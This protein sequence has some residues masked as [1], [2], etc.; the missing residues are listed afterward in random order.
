MGKTKP[1]PFAPEKDIFI[2]ERF[3]QQ[4][5]G[6]QLYSIAQWN[7]AR[8]NRGLNRVNPPKRFLKDNVY[9]HPGVTHRP[10]Y[11][12]DNFAIPYRRAFPRKGGPLI[13]AFKV[14]ANNQYTSS[15]TTPSPFDNTFTDEVI[16][17]LAPT[18]DNPNNAVLSKPGPSGVKRKPPTQLTPSTTPR[19]QPTP[20]NI[21]ST[22]AT[23]VNTRAN[24]PAMDVDP[25]AASSDKG[26]NATSDGGFDSAQ[27][28][29]TYIKRPDYTYRGGSMSFKKIH[30]MKS[31]ALPF[32]K[33][34]EGGAQWTVTPLTEIPWQYM[35]FYMSQDEFNRIPAGSY[36]N[37]CKI[38]I[39]VV[40]ASTGFVSG[41]TES[42]LATFQHPKIGMLGLDLPQ[43]L[44][45]GTTRTVNFGAN[46]KPMSTANGNNR[47]DFILKQY[48]VDQANVN[49]DM[50]DDNLA[51]LPGTAFPIVYNKRDYFCVYQP[52]LATA[53]TQGF[54]AAV[55]PGYEVLN[56]AIT[57]FNL[58]DRM[59]DSVFEREYRFESA[60]IGARYRP[61]EIAVADQQQTLG[62]TDYYNMQRNITNTGP[63]GAGG[64]LTFGSTLVGTTYNQIK[65][66]DY[67]GTEIEKGGMNRRGATMTKPARQPS[68]H[69]GI[70]QI[71][72]L[73]AGTDN[74]RADD[75]V[76]ADCYFVVTAEMDIQC[77]NYPNRFV[78]P[79]AFNVSIENAET[80]IALNS[81]A[82]DSIVT[83]G[84]KD[85]A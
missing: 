23:M 34:V 17:E 22:T 21:P 2:N 84:L 75:F 11:V 25:P 39:Q 6:R 65:L 70:K 8:E 42:E 27:G 63:S 54:T 18:L 73:Q 35:Y 52:S 20:A 71:P 64:N 81:S 83:F 44:R 51:P 68:V 28:P 58:N 61:L 46:L 53:V 57:Q 55:A 32:T 72:K 7:K 38:S 24:P 9:G 62:K 47:A 3:N 50:E 19:S 82:A 80:G 14:Q 78:L 1:E 10:G 79:K 41:G 12:T 30:H 29:D 48:G 4:S 76:F 43:K 69:F 16:D 56:S 66:V 60:P 77:N 49:W 36:V 74:T 13:D 26:H 59:W 45:G 40:A 37:S 15:T 33:K 31:F 67:A 85:L 5:Y